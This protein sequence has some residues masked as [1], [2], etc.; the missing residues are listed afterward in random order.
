[1]SRHGILSVDSEDSPFAGLCSF[2]PSRTVS[3]YLCGAGI[4]NE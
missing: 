1:M 3:K 2:I 4:G